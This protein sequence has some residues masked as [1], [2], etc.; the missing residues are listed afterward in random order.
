MIHFAYWK[1]SLHM[2]AVGA[3]VRLDTCLSSFWPYQMR[4]VG[5]ST[6]EVRGQQVYPRQRSE[7]IYIVVHQCT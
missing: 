5:L 6:K 3:V 1:P 7:C 2:F 4:E